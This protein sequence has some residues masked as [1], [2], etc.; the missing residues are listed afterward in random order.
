MHRH[1]QHTRTHARTHEHTHTRTHALTHS[2]THARTR[3]HTQ[4]NKDINTDTCTPTYTAEITILLFSA[5]PPVE[6]IIS[7][8]KI[9]PCL[10]ICCGRLG[11]SN[12]PQR[13]PATPYSSTACCQ[14]RAVCIHCVRCLRWICSRGVLGSASVCAEKQSAYR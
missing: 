1:T 2:R 8:K 12:R 6:Q 11:A 13:H 3:T 5:S 14:F 10:L 9:N 7:K 4:P